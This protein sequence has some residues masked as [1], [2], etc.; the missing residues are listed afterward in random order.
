MA[1][2][3]V[4]KGPH[5]MDKYT[6]AEVLK[7]DERMRAKY[8]ARYR[9]GDIVQI[10][11]DGT[12]KEKPHPDSKFYLVK[13][14]D[15]NFSDAKYLAEPL[16]EIIKHPEDEKKHNFLTGELDEVVTHKRRKHQLNIELL[17]TAEK[18]E[19]S[20]D[21]MVSISNTDLTRTLVVKTQ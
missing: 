10:Y 8:D 21:R 16:S 4:Y 7:F 2:F 12:C 17:G 14:P 5:W 20:K 9:P 11:P 3:L 13:V 19:L 6:E 18:N 15:V 1:E